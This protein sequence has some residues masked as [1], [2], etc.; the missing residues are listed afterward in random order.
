MPQ[1]LDSFFANN[2][3]ITSFEGVGIIKK[4]LNLNNNKISSLKNIP[5]NII[6]LNLEKNNIENLDF[7]PLNF[8]NISLANN[9]FHVYEILKIK[10][11][12]QEIKLNI[13]N[14]KTKLNWK[15]FMIFYTEVEFKYLN[16]LITNKKNN[17]C[18]KL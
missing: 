3:H 10:N 9:P 4:Q 14:K 15:E 7:L 11:K 1:L 5:E 6:N 2:N 17:H 18:K 13:N 8:K 12:F 16:S